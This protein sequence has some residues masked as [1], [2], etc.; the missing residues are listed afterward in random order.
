MPSKLSRAKACPGT[1]SLEAGPRSASALTIKLPC[2]ETVHLGTSVR[3]QRLIRQAREKLITKF[4]T[5]RSS[6]V[7]APEEHDEHATHRNVL[8]RRM[9]SWLCGN[10]STANLRLQIQRCAARIREPSA[11]FATRARSCADPKKTCAEGA[12]ACLQQA[13]ELQSWPFERITQIVL[14]MR[15]GMARASERRVRSSSVPLA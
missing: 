3:T 14:E 10:D 6:S 8:R 4:V 5:N 11:R 15:L 1:R 9:H 7:G 12:R 2:Q 13:A